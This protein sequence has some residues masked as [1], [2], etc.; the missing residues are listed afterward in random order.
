MLS[1]VV[2][3]T[4][5]FVDNIFWNARSNASGGIANIA[6]RLGG[7]APNPAGLT[8]NYND[9]FVSGTDG[10]IGFFNSAVVPTFANWKTVTGQDANSISANPAV[11]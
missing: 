1:D 8:S 10:A 3:N 5:N 4:R 6:I 9:L 2:T 11:C 7:T